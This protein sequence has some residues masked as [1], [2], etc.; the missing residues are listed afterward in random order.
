MRDTVKELRHITIISISVQ[1]ITIRAELGNTPTAKTIEKLLP[2]TGTANVWGDKIYF[3]IPLEIALEQDARE[4]VKV[5][6]LGY[7][8]AGPAFCIF[9]G[10]TPV[11][12]DDRT[13]A[14]SQ[15]NVFG[16]TLDDATVLRNVSGKAVV[17][18]DLL[19]E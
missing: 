14:Y 18:V 1:D 3:T 10:P 19:Q 13:R 8:P 9:F 5:G 2:L 7:W 11:N 15:V 17:N 16:R 12:T 4:N 6:E